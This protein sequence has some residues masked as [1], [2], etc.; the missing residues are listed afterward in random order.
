MFPDDKHVE[1]H[2]ELRAH[3]VNSATAFPRAQCLAQLVVDA[4]PAQ[5]DAEHHQPSDRRER[6]I[7]PTDSN[8]LRV[9]SP[10]RR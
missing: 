1:Q 4:Q 6:G 8:P 7:G 3:R 2:P 10:G 9:G 5:K